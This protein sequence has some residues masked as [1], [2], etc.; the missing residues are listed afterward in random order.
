MGVSVFGVNYPTAETF[1]MKWVFLEREL[2]KWVF[3]FYF[4]GWYCYGCYFEYV[5]MEHIVGLSELTA[6]LVIGHKGW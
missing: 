6:R 5:L 4:Y 2:G 1:L 3:Y